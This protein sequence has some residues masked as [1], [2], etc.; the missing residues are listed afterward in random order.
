MEAFKKLDAENAAKGQKT[1]Y[2]ETFS[3]QLA[4]S[5]PEIAAQIQT[6]EAN[7]T[8]THPTENPQDVDTART[9]A[10]FPEGVTPTISGNTLSAPDGQGNTISVDAS[11]T[12]PRRF[13]GTEGS[14]YQLETDMPVDTMYGP[15]VKYENAKNVLTPKIDTLTQ[16]IDY[17][18]TLTDTT[19]VSE[20]ISS[21]VSGLSY[22][23]KTNNP[24]IVTAIQSATSIQE[25]QSIASTG[26]LFAKKVEL[27]KEL[28]E[29]ETQY[30]QDLADAQ[31]SYRERMETRDEKVKKTLQF[32]TS[33]GF[34]D[35]PQS[36]TDTII[37]QINKSQELRQAIGINT[38]GI[39]L[40]E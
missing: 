8:V 22:T 14:N 16:I 24:E 7:F 9:G 40:A 3:T 35:M 25:L 28:S 18:G 29:A 12:P 21:I 10:A 38:D 31:A 27:E 15:T 26:I 5:S 6:F 32:L 19:L 34:T 37:S 4:S 30:K 23:F 1:Q 11:S 39:N 36:L 17:V 2:Y 20:A 33:I 13:I